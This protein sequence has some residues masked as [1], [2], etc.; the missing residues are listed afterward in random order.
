MKSIWR[1]HTTASTAE[2]IQR[3]Q[4]QV[5][6]LAVDYNEVVETDRIQSIRKRWRLFAEPIAQQVL[7]NEAEST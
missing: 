7:A 4:T 5:R 3:L 2:D 1:I 6:R